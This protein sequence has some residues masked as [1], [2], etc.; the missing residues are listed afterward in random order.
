MI[1]FGGGAMALMQIPRA[2]FL[3]TFSIFECDKLFLVDPHQVTI[4]IRS[5]H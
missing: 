3:K 4:L 5:Y 2:E 1:A